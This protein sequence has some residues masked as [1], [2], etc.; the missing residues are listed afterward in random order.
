LGYIYQAITL[1]RSEIRQS[2]LA[3][4]ANRALQLLRSSNCK[5][6]AQALSQRGNPLGVLAEA[7]LVLTQGI[8]DISQ[9]DL[10]RMP[11]NNV[12]DA[13]HVLENAAQKSNWMLLRFRY[14]LVSTSRPT[15]FATQLRILD[16]L[17]GTGYR[18]PLQ[19][20]L[21][22]AI[23]LHQQHRNAEGSRKFKFLRKSL[24]HVE[25]IVEVP[26]R[27]FWL[28]ANEQ[29]GYRICDA[30]VIESR[31]MRSA[32]K[33]QELQ[34]DFVP[35]VPLEFGAQEMRPGFTFKCSVN[36]GRY[37]PFLKPPQRNR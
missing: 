13:L 15:D 5:Q 23:L 19:I 33:V 21:E 24:A 6:Q 28:R 18:M 37:G 29:G 12:T 8:A 30:K 9:S 32:A 26:I 22:Y 34:E 4:L 36:F 25:A 2:E 35:F 20:E 7:W 10:S 16:E 17:E 31:G 11:P 3:R 1:E 27:L 14:D